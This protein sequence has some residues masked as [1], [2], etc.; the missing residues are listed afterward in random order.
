M[1]SRIPT[2]V[3]VDE[4][5]ALRDRVMGVGESVI[6]TADGMLVAADTATVHPESAAALAAAMLG[7]G[8]RTAAEFGV[9]G[10]RDVVTRCNGGYVVV[11]AIGEQALLVILGDEG[12]DVVGLH[13]E[14]PA[15]VRRLGELLGVVPT[16]RPY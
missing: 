9:G 12:L 10:L 2:T 6:S 14:S 15:T 13:R 11:L 7:L 1:S 3:L 4:L 16:V 8:R 5:H